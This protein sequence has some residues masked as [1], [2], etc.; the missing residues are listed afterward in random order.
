MKRLAIVCLLLIAFPAMARVRSV[1]H[2]QRI[3]WIGAHPDD[4]ALVAP[5]LAFAE[6]SAILVFTRG[7]HGVCVLPGGCGSDLGSIRAAEMGA[8]ADLLH[9][10]LTLWSF[11]D[12]ASDVDATWSAQAGSHSELVRRIESVIA[13]EKPSIIYTFDPNHG[14]TC[15]PAHR[16]AG[17]LALE[18]AAQAGIRV[19]LVETAVEFLQ[20]DF[21]FHSATPEATAIDVTVAWGS[22]VRDAE[23]HASQFTPEQIDALRNIPA[24]QRRVWQATAPARIDSCGR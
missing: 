18:A 10:H 1:G 9:A 16:A 2:Q 12:A 21:L 17:A 3:L 19:M 22:L 5:L 8:A 13:V 24:A 20:G 7:E 14:S 6:G 23:T 11:S 15:H 4:E